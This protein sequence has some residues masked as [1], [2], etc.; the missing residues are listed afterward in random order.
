M[1]KMSL[2]PLQSPLSAGSQGSFSR[3]LPARTLCSTLRLASLRLIPH[4]C[5]ERSRVGRRGFGS[6]AGLLRLPVAQW[7]PQHGSYSPVRLLPAVGAVWLALSGCSHNDDALPGPVFAV[8]LPD[9]VSVCRQCSGGLGRRG[10]QPPAACGSEGWNKHFCSTDFS[11]CNW[12]TPQVA[13]KR[14]H[15]CR[16]LGL[17]TGPQQVSVGCDWPM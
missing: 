5:P 11:S 1:Y 10:P 12:G 3:P 6:G 15:V 9:G 8:L 16:L 2:L 4:L 14:F 13:F 7:R 17:H